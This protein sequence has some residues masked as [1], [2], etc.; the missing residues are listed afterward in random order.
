MQERREV[1]VLSVQQE[2]LG[3]WASAIG[4]WCGQAFSGALGQ[5]FSGQGCCSAMGGRAAAV[6]VLLTVEPSPQSGRGETK[7]DAC[8]WHALQELTL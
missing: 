2:R 6:H 8:T 4:H 7:G 5:A 3:V 1:V